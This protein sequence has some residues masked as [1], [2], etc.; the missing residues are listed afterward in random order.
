MM[1]ADLD[2]EDLAQVVDILNTQYIDGVDQLIVA[3]LNEDG[4]I[5]G[6][7]RAEGDVYNFKITDEYILSGLYIPKDAEPDE[8]DLSDFFLGEEDA[9]LADGLRQDDLEFRLDKKNCKKGRPC[10]GSCISAAKKC[11]TGM[12]KETKEK[13]KRAKALAGGTSAEAP[14]P[15]G[16]LA[17]RG[18]ALATKPKDPEGEKSRASS[19]K[20][21]EAE[22]DSKYASSNPS[23]TDI[24]GWTKEMAEERFRPTQERVTDQTIRDLRVKKGMTSQDDPAE[25]KLQDKIKD[26]DS[27]ANSVYEIEKI[28]NRR[29]NRMAG[30]G[31]AQASPDWWMKAMWTGEQEAAYSKAKKTAE[32]PKASD[33]AKEAARKKVAKLEKDKADYRVLAEKRAA[34]F[35][36][37][38]NKPKAERI[39]ELQKEYDDQFGKTKQSMEERH[40]K[41]VKGDRRALEDASYEIARGLDTYVLE[42]KSARDRSRNAIREHLK[43]VNK[44]TKVFDLPANF[45]AQDL[46]KAYRAAAFKAH[47]DQGGN[48][49]KF[50]EINEA[51]EAL[52]TKYNFDSLEPIGYWVFHWD[53]IFGGEEDV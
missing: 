29:R 49:D 19:G 51:Y 38:N 11:R 18:G 24:D 2:T 21:R 43:T 35:K 13:V 16:A 12:P 30:G 26:R 40:A 22:I 17:T 7:F 14:E 4:D 27:Y 28:Q 32:S 10:G 9:Y 41:I 34:E 23:D 53:A 36:E 3:K 52:R 8:S 20:R 46:K 48:A 15:G 39:K 50:R 1:L 25:V 31:D 5:I 44:E 47:P 33:K 42:G 37:K 6:R 45:T